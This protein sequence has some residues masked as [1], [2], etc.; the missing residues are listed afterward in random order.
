MILSGPHGPLFTV[1]EW[2]A[3]QK[4]LANCVKEGYLTQAKMNTL[5][6]EYNEYVQNHAKSPPKV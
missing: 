1:Q 5:I 3:V 6:T 2:A 4:S